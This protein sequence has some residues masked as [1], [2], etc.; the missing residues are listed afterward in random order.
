MTIATTS[1]GQL[2]V[3]GQMA[4]DGSA[5]LATDASAPMAPDT[6]AQTAANELMQAGERSIVA[7]CCRECAYA[8]LTRAPTRTPLPPTVRRTD[9][10]HRTGRTTAPAQ[11][12][13]RR[14]RRRDGRR[15]PARP[16]SL[17]EA[18]S[19]PSTA[20]PLQ[21]PLRS[22][23]VEPERC[24]CSLGAGEPPK[25]VAAVR[26]M[27]RVITGSPPPR[28]AVARARRR[29]APAHPTQPPP[30]RRPLARRG[31]RLMPL[32]ERGRQILSRVPTA[33][34]EQRATIGI[35]CDIVRHEALRG[36]R[37]LRQELPQRRL[38]ARRS[39]R[40]ATTARRARG[41]PPRRARCRTADADAA[42]AR[43]PDRGP[44]AGHRVPHNRARR[45]QMPRM[46]N[47]RAQLP[48]DSHRSPP[49]HGDLR[50]VDRRRVGHRGE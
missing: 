17:R 5:R 41:Q 16:V 31:V 36:L 14:R 8:P 7:F 40:C 4:E 20:W 13:G 43:R 1:S 21:R 33:S 15:L 50:R 27:D 22:V 30:R 32:T 23:G 12:P 19:T 25:F 38:R 39:L 44:G 47:L 18:T 48:R 6:A 28:G 24:P 49:T 42:R 3:A 11:G 9:A 34:S 37:H 46:R 26:E 45:R 35:G 29:P 2:D 10:L